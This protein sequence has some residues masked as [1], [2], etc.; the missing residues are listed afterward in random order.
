MQ[1]RHQHAH[2]SGVRNTD[3]LLIHIKGHLHFLRRKY[4]LKGSISQAI[5]RVQMS[6]FVVHTYGP[7]GEYQ[8][9]H[10]CLNAASVWAFDNIVNL[11]IYGNG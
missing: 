8:D 9:L 10:V 3:F 7:S 11:S 1:K 6:G 5:F 4:Y 2:W